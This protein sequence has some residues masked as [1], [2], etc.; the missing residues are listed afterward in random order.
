MATLGS[1]VVEMSASTAKFESDLGRAAQMTERH[2][3]QIDNAI[4][5][6]KSSLAALGI[7][8]SLGVVIDQIK[9]KIE[10]SIRLADDLQNLSERTGASVESLSELAAVARLSNTD[11]DSLA[12]GL[13]RL[14]RAVVEAQ[15]GG[16]QTAAAFKA[17]GISIES[18]RGMGPEEVFKQIALQMEM[19]RDGVE[20]TTIA[21][22]LMGR[23]GANLL[24]VM[25]DLAVT[26]EFLVTVTTAQAVAADE[27]FKNMVRL[28]QSSQALFQ[29]V[30]MELVP[31]FN[32]FLKT[33]LNLQNAQ[34]GIRK[35]VEELASNGAFRTWAQDTLVALAVVSESIIGVV[36]LVSALA[37]SVQVMYAD[38]QT[39]IAAVKQAWEELKTFGKTDDSSLKTALDNRAKIL[40]DANA[41][42]A[43]LLKDGTTFSTALRK[44]FEISNQALATP[45][46]EPPKAPKPALPLPDISGLGNQNRF[47]DDPFKK[48]LEGQIKAIEDNIAAE[49]KLLANRVKMLDFYYGLQFTTLREAETKKQQ[50]LI[51]NLATVQAAYDQ[52]IRLAREAAARQGATQ[53]QI[54][55]ANNKA[56]EAMRKRSAAEIAANEVVIESSLKLLAVRAKF[57]LDTQERA[58]LSALDNKN[59][60]FAIDMMGQNTLAVLKLTAAR[61]IQ[62]EVEERIRL[63]Q[64]QDP[65]VD[66]SDALANAAI[67]IANATSLIEVAYNKQRSA[68]FGASEAVRKYQEEAG[69]AAAQVESAMTNAFQ[70]MEDALVQF[71]TTGKLSFSDLANSIVADITRII[72][73]QQISNALGVAGTASG[74]SGGFMSFIGTGL[75]VLFG[76]GGPE[77]LGGI[78]VPRAEGGPV[79][80]FGLYQVNE[81]G[82]ELLNLSSGRQYLLMDDQSG[83]VVPFT[84]Q[85]ATV[86]VTNNFTFNSPTDRRTQA[87]IA[88]QAGLS[89]QRALARNT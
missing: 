50:L 73:K 21:Q 33:L 4:G 85:G 36:K 47:R 3:A 2:M 72:I 43:E 14:S 84:A 83:E 19:Y 80:A 57:N 76:G 41:R 55:E 26:N 42:Y 65:T 28:G 34:N 11:L 37:G 16:K 20:K 38:V 78:L 8:V 59:A 89:V 61:E 24:P 45:S 15:N 52:E 49:N 13:Q 62:L 7:A 70:G 68:I 22:V 35:S 51:D 56:E 67:Q 81:R 64:L 60:Q 54:A 82:P 18:L 31:V 74:E 66:T 71:V 32:D 77:Q 88:T 29:I 86:N 58:R 9:S 25:K 63:L 48:I 17:L 44:Q 30:G 12:G 23:S 69:N 39:G 46:L 1:V 40:A 87:Q 5:M 53:V 79:S 75:S 27:M 10:S 6:V